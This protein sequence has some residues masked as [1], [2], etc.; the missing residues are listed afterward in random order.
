MGVFSTPEQLD[1][2]GKI[3]SRYIRLPFSGE[4]I[5]GAIMENVL[6]HVRNGQ[7]LNTYDFVDVIKPAEHIGW[8][9]KSTK[10]T[11]PVTWKRAKIP[12]AIELI[13]KSR[14]SAEG[15]KALG[16]AIISFCNSHVQ[17][18]IKKYALNQIGYS[19][20]IINPGGGV[21]YFER[22]LCTRDD[23]YIFKQDDFRWV[24]STPK[25]TTKK[26]QLQAL[27]G[28]HKQSGK[29][30]WAWH[31]L[32]EN[33]LHFCGEIVWWPENSTHH[34]IAFNFPSEGEKLSLEDFLDMLSK[35]EMPN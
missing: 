2:I 24:W 16:D 25:K 34:M 3:L 6:A 31:G 22:L 8:Q 12:N 21:T 19:R 13:E 26:E 9:V 15:C 14:K 17:Q 1:L 23:P 10:T 27:H 30:W 5:P 20:L 7:V 35:A 4:T 18:S 11:T 32:G 29:K 33:Q 28:I